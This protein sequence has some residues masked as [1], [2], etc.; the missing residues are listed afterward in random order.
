MTIPSGKEQKSPLKKKFL[1]MDVSEYTCREKSLWYA[2]NTPRWYLKSVYRFKSGVM[3]RIPIGKVE[4]WFDLGIDKVETDC[5]QPPLQRIKKIDLRV[6][7][8]LNL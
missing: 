6:S 8:N 7:L 3:V 5:Q 4:F 1:R 2:L